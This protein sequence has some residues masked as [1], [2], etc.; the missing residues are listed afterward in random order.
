LE[1]EF[2]IPSEGIVESR[3]YLEVPQPQHR[4]LSV[5][6]IAHQKMTIKPLIMESRQLALALETLCPGNVCT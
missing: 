5:S 4:K 1:L 2:A 6:F 3:D